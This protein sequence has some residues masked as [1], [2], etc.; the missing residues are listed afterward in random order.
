[1]ELKVT[2]ETIVR[3]SWAFNQKR[4]VPWWCQS[5]VAGTPL[6]VYGIRDYYGRV[7]GIQGVRTDEIPDRVGSENLDKDKYL[8]F[9]S[10]MLSWIKNSVFTEDDG[11]IFLIQWDPNAPGMGV[12]ANVLPRDADNAFLRD[13]YV[14]EME[15]YFAR[16]KQQEKRAC[17]P[18]SP[19]LPITGLERRAI[20]ESDWIEKGEAIEIKEVQREDKEIKMERLNKRF[21][22]SWPRTITPI[23]QSVDRR[24]HQKNREESR[25]WNPN[26]DQ[27]YTDRRFCQKNRE[28]SRDWNRNIDERYIGDHKKPCARERETKYR[29]SRSLSS[30]F[31]DEDQA[32]TALKTADPGCCSKGESFDSGEYEKEYLNSRGKDRQETR[33]ASP[34]VASDRFDRNQ[35][36]SRFRHPSSPSSQRNRMYPVDE[37]RRY[38]RG[39]QQDQVQLRARA[40]SERKAEDSRQSKISKR[41]FSPSRD[42]RTFSDSRAKRIRRDA[43]YDVQ[44]R[45]HEGS[46]RR[47]FPH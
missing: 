21:E 2:T 22:E 19:H 46:R 24:F 23:K 17:I 35:Q 26:I 32:R 29:Q 37:R 7:K 13:W 34:E 28:E 44:R 11:T 10:E 38:A 42:E 39:G 33:Q 36:N 41:S 4:L 3:A 1:M 14:S 9:L 8:L 45:R 25:N 15:D 30:G 6:I 12:T 43:E 31:D 47:R 5:I 20:I 16:C 27:R 40:W 18:Q